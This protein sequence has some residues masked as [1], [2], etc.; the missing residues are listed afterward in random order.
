MPKGVE[1]T[2]PI[3]AADAGMRVMSFVMPKGVEHPIDCDGRMTA[4]RVPNHL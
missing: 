2:T 1:H 3:S 4:E